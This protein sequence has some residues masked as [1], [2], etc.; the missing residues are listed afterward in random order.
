MRTGLSSREKPPVALI[1]VVSAFH[2]VDHFLFNR[3]TL[4]ANNECRSSVSNAFNYP[5]IVLLVVKMVIIPYMAA[6]G[7]KTTTTRSVISD[8]LSAKP[9]PVLNPG[10]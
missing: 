9:V 8:R 2:F 3:F 4:F 5:S 6:I 1:I 7:P 10:T